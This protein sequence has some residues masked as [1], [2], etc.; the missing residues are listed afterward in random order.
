MD[1]IRDLYSET[2]QIR[3]EC[4]ENNLADFL[5]QDVVKCVE[6][7]DL[8]LL[9]DFR[10][11]DAKCDSEMIWQLGRMVTLMLHPALLTPTKIERCMQMAIT[12]K[13]NS[14]CLSRQVGAVVTDNEY[15][16]LSLGWNDAPCG[17]ESC[18]RRNMF[19]LFR[20]H[21][22]KAYSEYEL[23]DFEFRRYL[24]KLDSF[25]D[26]VK[27]RNLKGLPYA[28]CFKDIYQNI[29]GQ[30]DQIYTRALHGE[31]RALAMCGNERAKGG[32]LFTT[33]SPCEL[34]AKKIK[35]AGINKIYYIEQY[36]GISQEHIINIG[37]NRAEFILFTGAIGEAYIKLYTPLI[38][39]KD[40]LKAVGYDP[41]DL[42]RKSIGSNNNTDSADLHE[43]GLDKD[44][45]T[46]EPDPRQVH[47]KKC[48]YCDRR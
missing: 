28:F 7:A 10:Q 6:N 34:C 17:A 5:L 11:Q 3:K 16:I 27:K 22:D 38:P 33:S 15:N 26:E 13:L 25:L 30:K 18:I 47:Q 14:G 46:I 42:Y 4:Y 37:R 20:N 35:E 8:F 2:G 1:F 43:D 21:D 24:D 31:E 19:D 32:Y 40:E 29:L 39:Y 48:C 45:D 23:H 36:K 12:A 9:R 44:N 41:V